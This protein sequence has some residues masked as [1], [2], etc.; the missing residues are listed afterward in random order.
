VELETIRFAR[1]IERIV[2]VHGLE[3]GEVDATHGLHAAWTIA[4]TREG[5]P[6]SESDRL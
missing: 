5:P 4:A 2:Q 3:F 1:I 6:R